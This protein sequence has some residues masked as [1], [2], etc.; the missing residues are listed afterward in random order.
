MKVNILGTEYTI[1]EQTEKQNPK[2][3][4]NYGLCE[5]YAKKIIVYPLNLIK[6]E[7]DVV[8]N[9]EEFHK[10]V[11]RHEVIHAFFGESGLRGNSDYAENEELIDWIAIQF[12][13]MLKVFEELGVIE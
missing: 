3:V 8:D 7:K 4:E 1:I 2:M 13:K 11:I 10:K 6:N 12:P 9:V 5:Q